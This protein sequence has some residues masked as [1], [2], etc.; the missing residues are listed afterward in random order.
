MTT[1]NSLASAVRLRVNVVRIDTPI[2][3]LHYRFTFVILVAC[4]ILVTLRQYIG[5]HIACLHDLGKTFNKV[6]CLSCSL[7]FS[8]S[9]LLASS[10][11][12]ERRVFH[13]TGDQHVLLHFDDVQRAGAGGGGA[14]W[15]GRGRRPRSRT[16]R[17]RDR[18]RHLPRLLPV[19]ALRPLRPGQ[20][21]FPF[22]SLLSPSNSQLW[23]AFTG[24]SWVL[25]DF[26]GFLP[27]FTG[28]YRVIL[29]FAGFFS[30]FL[31][32][33]TGFYWVLVNF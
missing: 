3:R 32:F 11:G 26:D 16:L 28:Y 13:A 9:P 14:G 30:T 7:V 31:W 25:L 20:A 17:R 4:T 18:R 15:R 8:F 10:D 24:F 19:G 23:L 22:F 33:F 2:F 6:S 29:D 21:S 27:D 1:F 12:V 5:E